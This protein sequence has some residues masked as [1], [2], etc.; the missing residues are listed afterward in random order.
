MLGGSRFEGIIS[1]S[2]RNPPGL[3]PLAILLCYRGLS[4]THPE[5]TIRAYADDLA[6]LLKTRKST[7]P[8]L[9]RIFEEDALISGLNLNKLKTLS[10]PL[11]CCDLVAW[12]HDIIRIGPAWRDISAAHKAK[13]L[14]FILVP[15]RGTA[16]FD[17]P[18]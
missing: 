16:T 11:H 1:T 10:I 13:Y 8:L 5:A 9:I 14:G 4:R 2:Q 12:R 6:L 3:S 17:N 18:L 7:L 15:E